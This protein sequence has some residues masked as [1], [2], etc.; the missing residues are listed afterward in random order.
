MTEHGYDRPKGELGSFP[1]HMQKE[2]I[3]SHYE[4]LVNHIRDIVL[5]VRR[6]D[7][8]ILGA[9]EAAAKNYGYSRDEL[10][11]LKI[12]DLRGP[13]GHS[14]TESQMAEADA[15]G[16]LFET[17]HLRKDGTTFPVE[18]SS[19]GV[20]IGQS[21]VLLSVVRDRTE[22]KLAEEALRESEE[23][24]RSVFEN[25]AVGMFVVH[26]DGR[27]LQSNLAMQTMLGYNDDEFRSMR[28]ADF[29]HPDDLEMSVRKLSQIYS[30]KRTEKH[31]DKRYLAKDGREIWAHVSVAMVDDGEGRPRY[32]VAV[33]EDITQRKLAEEALDKRE[34][35]LKRKS[36]DLEEADTALKVL[37]RHQDEDKAALE[38]GI[39]ANVRE[40]VLPYIAKLK[41][42]HLSDTQQIYLSFI[43][44]GLNEIVSPFLQR[45]AALS[46]R[47]TRAE[48][49]IANLIRTGKSSKEMA[50]VLNVSEGT[51]EAHR[52]SIRS[53]LG[54]K[55]KNINLQAHLLSL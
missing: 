26:Q 19:R 43:E 49:Q 28:F 14:H 31:F 48:I 22:R 15:S 32:H 54:L 35:E 41:S 23:R 11:S 1:G 37:L 8:C 20:A 16:I 18:V 21:R 47:F 25:A 44:S 4:C 17:E 7:G 45:T 6:A 29:T 12:F 46:P 40:L 38:H 24:F 53:K 9:N 50:E 5:F 36:I 3:L 27:I 51:I 39:Q 33:I 55:H 34:T 30:P 2:E 10:L 52:N 42:T 13:S